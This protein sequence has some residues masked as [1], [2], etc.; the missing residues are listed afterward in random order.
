MLHWDQQQFKQTVAW[1]PSTNTGR[2][3]LATGAN[4]Y[5]VFAATVESATKCETHEHVAYR[6][7]ACPSTGPHINSD[8]EDTVQSRE[9]PDPLSSPLTQRLLPG[10]DSP[11]TSPREE[12]LTDLTTEDTLPPKQVLE[13]DEELLS[14][15]M[16][17][18][19]LLRWHYRLGHLPFSR[20]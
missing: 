3:K 8:E 2:L 7:V 16:P 4:T 5:R 13:P 14:A 12:N 1:Y 17:Q 19:E 11:A 10:T 20:L 18:A 9:A 15:E 6:F